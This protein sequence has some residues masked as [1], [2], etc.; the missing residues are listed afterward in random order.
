MS[1]DAQFTKKLEYMTGESRK[2]VKAGQGVTWPA[3]LSLPNRIYPGFFKISPFFD[4]LAVVGGIDA[5]ETLTPAQVREVAERLS[6]YVQQLGPHD[7]KDDIQY[8]EGNRDAII[9][10]EWARDLS[11]LFTFGAREGMYLYV[12]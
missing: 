10:Y 9:S 4:F 2:Q 8:C 6:V 7:S 11:T 5:S 1:M 3:P 12:Y